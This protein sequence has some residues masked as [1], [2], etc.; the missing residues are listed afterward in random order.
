METTAKGIRIPTEKLNE[1][2]RRAAK[3]GLTFNGWI[4]WAIDLGLRTHSTRRSA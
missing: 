4:N 1:I 2:E 3:K